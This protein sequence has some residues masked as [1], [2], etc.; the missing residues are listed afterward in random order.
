MSEDRRE[1]RERVELLMN[2]FVQGHAKKL[3]FLIEVVID[4]QT[5]TAAAHTCELPVSTAK[6]LLR[7]WRE[8]CGE[9]G[10]EAE[11]VK[12]RRRRRKAA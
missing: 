6:R 2:A 7:E 12:K 10:A 3:L 9:Q 5:M 8:W 1:S 11:P 4:G